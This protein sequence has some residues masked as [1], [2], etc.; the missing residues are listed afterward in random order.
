MFPRFE[1]LKVCTMANEV[2]EELPALQG[3]SHDEYLDPKNLWNLEIRST[4]PQ[5]MQFYRATLVLVDIG[6][7]EPAA[8]LTRSIN[9]AAYRFRY[10]EAN[11]SELPDWTKWQMR[12]NFHLIRNSLRYDSHAYPDDLREILEARLTLF[13]QVLGG[14]PTLPPTTWR[15]NDTI[16]KDLN[17]ESADGFGKTVIRHNI[18][19]FSEYVHIRDLPSPPPDLVILAAEFH[20][21]LTVRRAM[22]LCLEKDLLP[23]DVKEY[24]NRIVHACEALLESRGQPT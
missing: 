3:P 1:V 6:M 14:K 23:N 22:D 2:L 17:E 5:V 18:G 4:C 12:K 9:E 24:A 8:A 21:L 10:L 11:E 7:F 13:E 16:I 15:D 19:L 20:T